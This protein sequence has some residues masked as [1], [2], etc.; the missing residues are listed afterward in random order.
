MFIECGEQAVEVFIRDRG[1]GFDPQ[2]IDPDR[3]GVRESILGRME[4]AGGEAKIRSGEQGT[5]I[6]LKMPRTT[7]GKANH[8][9]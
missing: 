5:E 8:H 1:D 2:D 4:R 7:A 6:Q 9:D 3:Q